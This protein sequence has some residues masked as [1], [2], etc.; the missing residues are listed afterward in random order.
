MHDPK[1]RPAFVFVSTALETEETGLHRPVL[2]LFLAEGATGRGP[3]SDAYLYFSSIAANII[4]IHHIYIPQG[5][6]AYELWFECK[7]E[8]F[9]L[10]V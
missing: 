8:L 7:A 9:T 2:R 10:E 6:G 3:F 1:R 5:H 4:L